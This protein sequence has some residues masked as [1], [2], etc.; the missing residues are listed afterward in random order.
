[1]RPEFFQRLGQL[2]SKVKY[3][4]RKLFYYSLSGKF[5]CLGKWLE[6]RVFLTFTKALGIQ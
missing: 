1:M 3:F 6:S 5:E 4:L 2:K